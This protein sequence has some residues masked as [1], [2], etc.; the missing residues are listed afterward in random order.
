MTSAIPHWLDRTELLIGTEGLKRLMQAHV[1]V[2]GLGG[3]GGYA[4]EQLARAGIG[5]LTIIDGDT[6]NETNRNRQIIAL[7]STDKM[8]KTDVMSARLKDI[9]PEI[10]LYVINEFIRDQK[11]ID[12]LEQKYD[13]VIDAIDTLSPKLF[14]IY[15]SVTKGH[16]LISSMGAGG[17]FDPA[18]VMVCDIS[19][20]YNCRLAFYIRKHLHRMKIYD[21][22]DVVFSPER[23]SK[24]VVR[25]ITG[26]TNKRT[27][28]GT[29][30]YMPPVFGCMCAS[31]VIRYLLAQR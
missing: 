6:V 12:I 25:E 19:Q 16:R 23:V 24:T 30:S 2:A 31:V 28:V 1:L 7:Q 29:I 17:K 3:V 5:T 18:K 22:F 27:T 14:F 26:E 20:S 10:R 11:M 13:Y 15:H 21:G 4:A 8:S 9:N